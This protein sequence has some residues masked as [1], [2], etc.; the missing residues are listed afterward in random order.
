M[1]ESLAKALNTSN[2][3]QLEQ[4]CPVDKVHALGVASIHVSVGADAIHFIDALQPKSYNQLL[5]SLMRSVNSKQK[6][7]REMNKKICEQVIYEACATQ[8]RTCNGA[9]EVLAGER[10]ITC[11]TCKGIGVHRYDDKSRAEA[12]GLSVEAY[13]KG[14]HKRFEIA[15]IVF[16]D[17]YRN[18]LKLTAKK[19]RD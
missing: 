13:L 14:W 10:V 9:K 3:R 7:N 15:Q 11:Q 6:I 4:D 2:L 17:K 12:L 19:Y 18:V 5:Y 1:K 8:C 16:S